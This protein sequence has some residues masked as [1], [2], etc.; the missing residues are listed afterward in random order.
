MRHDLEVSGSIELNAS[1]EKLWKG[2]TDPSIIKD[3]LF[4]TETI[5]DWKPGSEV[6]FQGEY[7]GHKYRD[8]GIILENIHQ[9]KISYSYWSGFSGLE[10]KPE[11]YS[12]I[13]YTLSDLGSG[14]TKF[15]WTQ[16]GFG[17]EA[18]HK[19][20]ESGMP[21]FMEKIKEVIEGIKV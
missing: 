12:T 16:K 10:D 15:T 7:E 17:N 2:L 13:T 21:A 14:R 6:I 1:L 20:S 18:G 3:Y 9:Q 5:T 8:K 4:G 19:H 11:N